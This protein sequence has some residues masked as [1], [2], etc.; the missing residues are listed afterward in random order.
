M[1]GCEPCPCG[2]PLLLHIFPARSHSD[3]NHLHPLDFLTFKYHLSLLLPSLFTQG[4]Q[5]KKLGLSWFLPKSA[6]AGLLTS[7]QIEGYMLN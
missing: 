2:F 1:S 3:G 5:I 4:E 6:T 7:K